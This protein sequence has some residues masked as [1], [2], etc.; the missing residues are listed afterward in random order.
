MTFRAK[1]V[2]KRPSRS[3]REHD[4]RRSLYMNIGFAL[5]VVAAVTILVIGAGATWWADA[6]GQV[7]SVNGVSI[8]RNDYRARYKI[9]AWRMNQAEGRLR[10]EFNAGRLT[11]AA[12]DS[13]IAAIERQ[14]Q[15]LSTIVLERLVDAASASSPTTGPG[16]QRDIDQRLIDEATRKEQ[17]HVWVIE[18]KPEVAVG[19]SEPTDAQVAAAK[20]KAEAAAADLES[21]KAWEDVAKAVSTASS[22]AQGGD[23]G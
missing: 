13:G 19:A 12:R 9:E 14:K 8:S 10:D 6:N 2:A 16:G 11:Q 3:S 4:S 22:S 5:V 17:R 7:A 21:G 18:V 15:S 23:L 20:A 1:P